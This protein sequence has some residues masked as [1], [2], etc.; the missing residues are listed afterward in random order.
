MPTRYRA[1]AQ[2]LEGL[3]ETGTD[4][5][6]SNNGNIA[7]CVT[8]DDL[9]SYLYIPKLAK[10]FNL[11]LDQS[12]NVF[13]LSLITLA[14]ILSITGF[15]LLFRNRLSRIISMIGVIA[16]SMF[17]YLVGDVYIAYS[18][19]ILSIVPLLL[20]IVLNDRFKI[21][22]Y[23]SVLIGLVLGF[24]NT[25]RSVSGSIVFIF[26]ILIVLFYYPK[27]KI[28]KAGI[29]GL[30]IL[31]IMIP[32]FHLKYKVK[33]RDIYL[34]TQIINYKPAPA[35]HVFW[36]SIYLGFGYLSNDYGIRYDD[37]IAKEKA[38]KIDS[39]AR[40]TYPEYETII[41]SETIKLIKRDPKLIIETLMAKFGVIFVVFLL[42]SNLGFVVFFY[43]KRIRPIENSLFVLI[44][45]SSSF[46][47]M[48][49]PHQSY[50]ICLITASVVYGIYSIGIFLQQRQISREKLP[51]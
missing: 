33:K 6:A 9:G 13:Y 19:A 16:V 2:T 35:Q 30:I 26:V 39:T 11:T 36:H 12:I 46:S 49:V 45:A 38:N 43:R 1:L 48:V 22:L 29:I 4:L 40:Y 31:G 14:F 15:F 41:K 23:S 47:F 17:S 5:I 7:P 51:K 8:H 3:K 34:T 24:S 25:V 10:W 27:N 18:F 44:I 42:C 37:N 20:Y 50:L 21:L 32:R 28:Y